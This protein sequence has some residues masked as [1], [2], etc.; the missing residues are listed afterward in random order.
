MVFDL[1][2]RIFP[3]IKKHVVADRP[4]LLGLS[5]GPDSICLLHLLLAYKKNHALDLHL[6]HID[7]GWRKESAYEHD[8]IVKLAKQHDLLIHTTRLKVSARGN[9]EAESREK[10]F[11]FFQK[12]NQ[13]IR[14]QAIFLAHHKNDQ[15]ETVFK[16][17]LEGAS[18]G[19][20]G[21]IRE[22]SYMGDLCIVRPLLSTA[23]EEILHYLQKKK[24]SYFEDPTNEEIKY[25]RARM[26]QEIF[27]FLRTSFGKAFEEN[28]F[29]IGEQAAQLDAY[30]HDRCKELIPPR[31][32]GPFGYF[33]DCRS[34]SAMHP[35]EV[36]ECVRR[37]LAFQKLSRQELQRAICMILDRSADK[38]LNKDLYFDRG[39]L[40][41]LK[42]TKAGRFS[43]TLREGK[44]QV[45]CWE[46]DV[47]RVKK[48]AHPI[49]NKWTDLM[50]GRLSTYLLEGK[51]ILCSPHFRHRRIFP[52]HMYL[53]KRK[54]KV[55]GQILSEHKVPRAL[56]PY[57]PMIEEKD[58]DSVVEDFLCGFEQKPQGNNLLFVQLHYVKAI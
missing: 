10:R 50:E 15:V 29:H 49:K 16:R 34:F 2:R 30:M 27:P 51:Y 57:C 41:C 36:Q 19:A 37:L 18:F 44:Q 25:L 53:Q 14:A 52:S 5:G 28:I 35:F 24:I 42:K 48:G 32:Q 58:S 21:S 47:Q 33:I 6:V 54:E 4:V 31:Q 13:E 12:I 26:R 38:W 1:E 20:I 46:V 17:L 7:H 22:K 39:Y 55:L 3:I 40:F 45:G 8:Q 9:Q 11:E 56:V 23:K 43:A